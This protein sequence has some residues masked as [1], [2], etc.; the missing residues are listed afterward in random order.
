MNEM[1]L[2]SRHRP[3]TS[4]PSSDITEGATR[5]FA[6]FLD[7]QSPPTIGRS[8][9]TRAR[10]RRRSLVIAGLAVMVLAAGGVAIAVYNGLYGDGVVYVEPA[11][12][13]METAGLT[14]VV[15]DSNVGPCL[16]VRTE[17]GMAG[18]CGFDFDDPLNVGA[19]GVGDATF[20]S[21]W[22]P[23]GTAK[24]EMTFPGGETV[25]VTTFQAV[26]GYDIVFFVALL[27]PS[28]GREPS[29]PSQTVAYDAQGN[30]LATHSFTV[31]VSIPPSP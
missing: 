31:P 13:I 10:W 22:A 8:G 29:A 11:T 27:P 26:E 4:G 19:G 12:E 17:R 15:Q 23:P 20:T 5:A 18:G 30:T 3:A 1:D 7:G 9:A 2:L 24:V 14:L 25:M 16:E 21:G 6:E 28:F